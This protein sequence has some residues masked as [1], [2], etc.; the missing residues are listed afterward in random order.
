MKAGIVWF[1]LAVAILAGS[2]FPASAGHEITFYP[3]Y[4][5]HEIRIDTLQ[6][7]AAATRLEDK[8]L[9]A[10]IGAI[11]SNDESLPKHVKSVESLGSILVL[12][13]N[14]GAPAFDSAKSRCSAAQEVLGVL[15]KAGP[16]FVFHPYP[17]T[18]YHADY[19]HHLDRIEEAKAAIEVES[20]AAPSLKVR[21]KGPHAEAVARALWGPASDEWEVN[22]EEVRVH[23][24]VAG[25]GVWVNGWLGPPWVKEGWFQAYRLLAPAL[26][27]A[28]DRRTAASIY[29]DLKQGAYLN[30]AEQA[31]LER[32]LIATLTRGCSRVVVGYTVRREFYNGDSSAGIEN[33][34]YDSQTGLN[35]PVF[36]RTVKLK[37]YP[38]NGSLH[39]GMEGG[40]EGEFGAAWNPVGGFTDEAGRL[41]W[42]IV[43]DPALMPL[44][45]NASWIPN[46]L[47]FSLDRLQGRSGGFAAPAGSLRPQEGTGMLQ[48]VPEAAVASAKLVYKVIASPFLDGTETEPTDI[49]YTLAFA[50]RWAAK[51][52]SED[53]AFEP[54]VAAA[55]ADLR[56]RLVGIR[57]L[58]VDKAI[59]R[60]APGVSVTKR[61][62]VLEIYL[63]DT[64]GDPQQVAALAPPWSTIPWHLLVLMEEVVI[65]GHAAFSKTEAER[66]GVKWLDLVRDP[67]LLET[68]RALIAEFEAAGYRPA[69]LQQLVTEDE[70]RAR[71]RALREFAEENGHFLVTNGPYRLEAW[72]SQRVV[73]RA[74]RELTYPLGFGTFDRYVHPLRAVV[75]EVLRDTGGITV[76]VDA[77]KTVKV[78]RR[79]KVEVAPLSRKVARGIYGALVVSR[80]LL[81]G[82]GGTVM[83]ADKM[84]WQGDDRFRVELPNDLPP[85]GYTI[86]VAVYLDGNSLMPS[87]GMLRFEAQG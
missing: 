85:G 9:H 27:D 79:T 82:P 50:H 63:R 75:R 40:M 65:H 38:W 83:G 25:T 4:Y 57:Y 22:L 20:P 18:P 55:S 61:T 59:N 51:A 58:R 11:S 13:F 74:V 3:S 73:F 52:G 19:L 69:A 49:L 70:A 24:L 1:A 32:R 15:R 84:Q 35:S 54:L 2:W 56:A 21:A 76:R 41:I 7:A 45:Y 28:E 64:P 31:D 72:T 43:G 12:G 26:V 86:L 44:P 39:L 46:R 80:Y 10:Y 60:I 29:D 71:W 77:E 53:R 6:P 30:L 23:D 81:I 67:S 48:P 66:R 36:V 37:D 5:P 78:G 34:G 42:S 8:T 33:I 68:M 87:T 14:P 62:P 16:S 17:V 47:D